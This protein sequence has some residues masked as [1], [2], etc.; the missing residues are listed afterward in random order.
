MVE[1][2]A[3]QLSVSRAW[4]LTQTSREAPR[5]TMVAT[6]MSTQAVMIRQRAVFAGAAAPVRLPVLP[7][8]EAGAVK[9]ADRMGMRQT[10]AVAG[11]MNAPKIHRIGRKI[12]RRK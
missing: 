1:L 10:A 9:V 11:R 5:A 8:G 12:P 2:V 3:T 4:R 7:S 6:T